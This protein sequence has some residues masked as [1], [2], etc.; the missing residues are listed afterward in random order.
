MTVY[1]EAIMHHGWILQ[2]RRVRSCHLVADTLEEL[3]VFAASVGMRRSWFQ[4]K[5]LPHYDLTETRREMAVLCGAVELSRRDFVT[6]MRRTQ[7]LP[8]I[9]TVHALERAAKRLSLLVDSSLQA[10]V[11][12]LMDAKAFTVLTNRG[13][14]ET[15]ELEVGGKK[16]VVVADSVSRTIVTILDRKE[17]LRRFVRAFNKKNTHSKFLRRAGARKGIVDPSAGEDE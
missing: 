14:M 4:E 2:G 13:G 12:R 10:E 16:I 11:S 15:C 8:W 5:R 7:K 17:F 9:F 1:V 3:H 6:F